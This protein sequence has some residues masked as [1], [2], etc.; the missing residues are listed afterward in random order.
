M[1]LRLSLL[2]ISVF[3]LRV[4][5]SPTTTKLRIFR[6]VMLCDVLK[7]EKITDKNFIYDSRWRPYDP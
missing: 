5:Q 6:H 3:K 1:K 2:G 7:A 4:K